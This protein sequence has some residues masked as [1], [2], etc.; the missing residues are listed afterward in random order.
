MPDGSPLQL[1]GTRTEIA[2]HVG[3]MIPKDAAAAIGR[4]ALLALMAQSLD[5]GFLGV[6]K[7][8]VSPPTKTTTYLEIGAT[9]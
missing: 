3:N 2:Q 8:W 4:Q 7:V 1:G 6:G 9:T 5:G